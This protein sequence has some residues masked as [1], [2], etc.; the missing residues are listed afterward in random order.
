[1][2]SLLVPSRGRP[3]NIERLYLSARAT[4]LA[5]GSFELIV[6]LDEDDPSLDAYP[7]L[8]SIVRYITGPRVVLSE[9]W[10]ECW[11]QARGEIF[12]HGGDDVTFESHAWDRRVAEAFPP[13]GIA[14]VHGDDLG[15]KGDQL[16]THGF[17]RRE[18]T[19]AVG[20]FVPPYFASD[21]NDLWLN[22]VGQAIGRRIYLPDVITEH[23]HFAFGKAPLDQ[24]H[25]D[26]IDRHRHTNPEATWE[27]TAS[28]RDAWADKLRAV[29]A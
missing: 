20:T 28:E 2:I 14:F 10:N 8:G 12:W 9:M 27:A 29:M 22:D 19:D 6:R 23:H 16:G 21:Y 15:G 18:W 1:M 5:A 24:T 13:D 11:R 26:R 7:A 4:H 25:Q 3:A 17:L